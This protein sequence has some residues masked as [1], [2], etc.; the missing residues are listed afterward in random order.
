[1]VHWTLHLSVSDLLTHCPRCEGDR[2][3]VFADAARL[4]AHRKKLDAWLL[5]D[6][7]GCGATHKVVLFRRRRVADVPRDL[8]DLLHGSDGTALRPLA[9]Q[10]V[11]GSAWELS[12][13]AVDTDV[14]LVVSVGPGVR[15]RLDA[16]L[17]T[18]LSCPRSAV[19]DRVPSLSRRALRRPVRDGQRL[20]VLAPFGGRAVDA[21]ETEDPP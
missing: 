7:E 6:C 5:F 10:Q 15:A 19:A 8:L 2:R 9:A 1:V 20:I 21:G 11:G 12:G 17:A 16:M 18:G 13:A 3:H 14:Q 4:N